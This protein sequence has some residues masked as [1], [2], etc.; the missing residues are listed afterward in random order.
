MSKSLTT[1]LIGCGQAAAGYG[2]DAQY[3]EFYRYATHVDVLA[4]H[5]DFTWVAAVDPLAEARSAITARYPDIAVAASI[6]ELPAT[7]PSFDVAVIATPA[8]VRLQ[9]LDQLPATVTAVIVEKPLGQTV[10]ECEKFL[11]RASERGITVHVNLWRRADTLHRELTG[12]GLHQRIGALQGVSM[13][14]GG[15]LHTTAT[16]LVDWLAMVA[17]DIESVQGG[18][19]Y[20]G[21]LR[22]ETGVVAML[23][24]LDFR[25]YREVTLDLWGTH[26]RLTIGNE[27]LVYEVRSLAPH[28]VMAG[29]KEIAG[30]APGEKLVPTVGEA[31]YNLY[32]N[33]ARV[34]QKA[35]SP[36]ASGALALQAARVIA[37]IEESA[38]LN[39][40]SVRL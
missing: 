3:K 27:A 9:L 16:H 22:S 8:T 35:E 26:G 25:H 39:G 28:R 38:R 17:G 23:L 14:Y 6:K 31:F 33:V 10:R 12:R 19:Q 20:S 37:A 18:P 4:E 1:L 40:R 29:D 34:E 11:A 7:L 13:I 32:T 15:G 24:A 30:D 36:L 21:I 5:P 2:F